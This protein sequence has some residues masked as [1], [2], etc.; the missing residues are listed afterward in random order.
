VVH[1]GSFDA[2]IGSRYGTLLLI[3]LSIFALVFGT[4]A[5]NFLRVAPMLGD[6]AGTQRLRRS[7]SFE[8]AVGAAVLLVTA[9]LVATARPY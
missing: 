5:Y 4:G 1:V 3:K 8:V 9:V 6:D 2:L 7:A